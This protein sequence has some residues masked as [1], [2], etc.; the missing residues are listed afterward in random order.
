MGRKKPHPSSKGKHHQNHQSQ[1]KRTD[2]NPK[3][4]ESNVL[5]EKL[6]RLCSD[7]V[8]VAR[9]WNNYIELTQ[10]LDDIN[11]LAEMKTRETKRSQATE[12]FLQWLKENNANV[13]SAALSEFSGYDMGLKANKDF[14]AGEIIL[15]IPGSIILSTETAAPELSALQ[16]DPLIQHMPQVALAIALLVERHKDNSKWKPY[17]DILPNTYCTVLY[18]SALELGEL[19]GSPTLEPALKQSRNIVRQFAYFSQMFYNTRN[20]VSDLLRPYFNWEEYRWAV[21]TVM[22]RQNLIPSKNGTQMIHALIPMWDMCNHE[23]GEITTDFNLTSDTCVC[24]A[25]RSFTQGEQ[26]FINY[27]PR[28]NSDFFV[29]SGFVYPDNKNDGFKLRLGISKA[30]N[31]YTDRINLLEKLGFTAP[32]VTF[33]LMSGSEP[34]T[35]EMLAFLRVFSMRK[36]ELDH[37]LQS[38]K[39]FDLKHRDCALDTVVEENVRK[40]LLTRLKLLVAN[41]PTTLEEDLVLV[42]TPMTR[43]RMMPIQLRIL[44]KRILLGALDYVEQWMKA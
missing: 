9:L 16:N 36:A 43:E 28:T 33:L 1:Q 29:H 6:F 39:V 20:P 13:D 27:G 44:E 35:E 38:D 22:T 40:F 31:L 26:I 14:A 32:T 19:K 2:S 17:L 4:N 15:E 34:I 30:D 23:E 3:K 41:Y 8:D 37:W 10:V 24:Y 11:R 21:S 18:M 7:P 5:C 25:K 42:T 12:S